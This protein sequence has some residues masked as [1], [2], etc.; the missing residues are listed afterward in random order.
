MARLSAEQMEII[1]YF[2]VQFGTLINIT[3]FKPLGFYTRFEDRA[4]E[5]EQLHPGQGYQLSYN[6]TLTN[7]FGGVVTKHLNGEA[8]VTTPSLHRLIDL[9]DTMIMKPY[10]ETRKTAGLEC[11]IRMGNDALDEDLTK[12][13]KNILDQVPSGSVMDRVTKKFKDGLSS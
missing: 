4:E 7:L 1:K 10:F 11:N 13:F 9:Y 6:E 3:S 12:T 5:L 2:P 8:D